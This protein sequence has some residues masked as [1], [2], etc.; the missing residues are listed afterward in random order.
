[1]R[2][3]RPGVSFDDKRVSKQESKIS[4]QIFSESRNISE[5]GHLVTIKPESVR[6]HI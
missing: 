5:T 1:M 4:T 2:L 6:P 3:Q